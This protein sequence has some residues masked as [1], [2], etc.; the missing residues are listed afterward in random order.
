MII[1]KT[2]NLINKKIYIGKDKYNNPKYLGSGKILNQ[3]IKKYGK[4]NFIKEIVEYCDSQ[5]E[6]NIKEKFWIAKLNSRNSK[7]G[8]NIAEGGSGGDTISTNPRN[9]IIRKIHSEKMKSAKFNKKIGTKKPICQKKD[10][11]NW[12]NPIK[13]ITNGRKGVP[14]KLKGIKRPEH[15]KRMMGKNNPSYGKKMSKGHSELL[16]SLA[17]MPKSDEHKKHLSEAL[18]GNKPPNMKKISINDII[19]PSLTEASNVL[20]IPLSTVKNRLKNKKFENYKYL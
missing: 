2:T 17:R 14:S 1:Y 8:Y 11:P 15:S 4:E 3:A 10:D 5:D 19:Y 7:I 20:N 18:K 9:Y 6:L 12:K 13:G 16:K